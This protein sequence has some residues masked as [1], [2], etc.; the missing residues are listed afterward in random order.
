MQICVGGG[1]GDAPSHAPTVAPLRSSFFRAF[2]E[3]VTDCPARQSVT[4][5]FLPPFLAS[6]S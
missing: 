3:T 5:F 1:D 4:F 2:L 6:T